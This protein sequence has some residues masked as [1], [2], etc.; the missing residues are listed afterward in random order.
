MSQKYLSKKTSRVFPVEGFLL[1][2]CNRSSQHG[3]GTGLL[4]ADNLFYVGLRID[5]NLKLLGK[6]KQ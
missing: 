6:S 4:I 5:N 3:F 1:H 2:R